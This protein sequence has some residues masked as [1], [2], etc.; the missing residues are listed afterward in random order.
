MAFN[1]LMVALCTLLYQCAHAADFR[2]KYFDYGH[3]L[4]WQGDLG[5]WGPKQT[6]Y[7]GY[8]TKVVFFGGIFC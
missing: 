5:D 1:V 7:G 8:A 6:C 4:E 3:Y 2:Q